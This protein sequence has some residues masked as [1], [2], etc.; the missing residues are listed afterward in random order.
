VRRQE[1]KIHLLCFERHTT[2]FFHIAT[3]SC[4]YCSNVPLSLSTSWFPPFTI[5]GTSH[6][7]VKSIIQSLCALTMLLLMFTH[8][9]HTMGLSVCPNEVHQIQSQQR[10][11]TGY[12]SCSTRKT[13][14][15]R[16]TSWYFYSYPFVFRPKLA[17]TKCSTRC[18][19]SYNPIQGYCESYTIN[20]QFRKFKGTK[21][22]PLMVSKA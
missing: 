1:T 18:T 7:C 12:L 11:G 17:C 16:S 3:T 21:F 8:L 22:P 9:V 20:S 6:A 10:A 19:L 15:T 4:M 14:F 5:H 2:S 13:L